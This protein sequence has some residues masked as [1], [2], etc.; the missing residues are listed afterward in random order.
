M[1]AFLIDQKERVAKG[2]DIIPE[3]DEFYEALNCDTIDIV[4]R[5]V[6]GLEFD[7]VC[8][9]E[10]LFKGPAI[11]S[12]Y[13]AQGNPALVGNLL[14]CHHNSDGELTELSEDDVL[15]LQAHLGRL[16]YKNHIYPIINGMNY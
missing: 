15:W 9:D 16:F 11:P 8:D 13:T 1:R 12:A 14:F 5:K 2:I 4:V 6:D 7:I 3:L 10:G